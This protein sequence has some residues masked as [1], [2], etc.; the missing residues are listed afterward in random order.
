MKRLFRSFAGGEID[1]M[2]FG[3]VDLV[4]NQTGLQ[5]CKNF[6]V[7]TQGPIEN[8]PGFKFVAETKSNSTASRLIPFLFSDDQTF[9]IEVG[10]NYFR[11][12][13]SYQTL[14][15]GSPAA[16]S[17]AT[18][19]EIG[20]LVSSAGVNYYCVTPST[21]N[22]PPNATY[23]YAMPAGIYEIPHPYTEPH[24][25]ELHYVQSADVLT[26]VHPNYAPRELQRFG[27]TTWVL[28]TVSF[29]PTI[30]LPTGVSVAATVGSGSTSYAYVVTALSEED[31][32]ESY[33]SSSSSTTNDLTTAGNYNTV[34]WSAV[35]GAVRYNVYKQENG[36]FG[37][38]GQTDGTS[39]IDENV[40]PDLSQTPPIQYTPLSGAG[41]FPRAVTYFER[42]RIF[43]GTENE[44]QTSYFTKVATES[45]LSYSIPSRDDDSIKFRIASRELNVIRHMVPLRDLL[46]LSSG[47]EFR[48][49]S[50]NSD[51]ITPTT[52]S[53]RP[54]SYE[55]CNN[56]QPI[57][58]SSSVLFCQARGGRVREL[59]FDFDSAGYKANDISLLATHL[60]D[61]YTIVD[62]TFSKAPEKMAYFV[63]SDG[64][65]LVLSYVPD[66]QIIAWST[67]E[68]DGSIESVCSIPQG[69]SDIVYAVVKRVINGSTKRYIEALNARI[70]EDQEDAFFVDSGLVFDGSVQANL[71]WGSDAEAVGNTG[72]TFT[73][74]SSVFVSGDVG[75]FIYFRYKKTNGEYFTSKALI[76][77]FTSGTEVDATIR[78]EFPDV[79]SAASGAWRMTA[80]FISGLDHLEGKTVSIFGDGAVVPQ[81]VVSSG[82]ITLD[83]PVAY[84]AIGLPYFSDMQT[85]PMSIEAQSFG[86][87]SLKSVNKA[88][89]RVY[90]SGGIFAGPAFDRLQEVKQRSNEPYGTPPLLKTE[91]IPL[92]FGASWTRDGVVC[93]RQ[94]DPLPLTVL[95][96]TAELDIESMGR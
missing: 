92:A 44:P 41:N 32:E 66:Q 35:S 2:L 14:G 68:T 53:V 89:I 18:A 76:T 94:S 52:I 21:G 46:I 39:F 34:S 24:L 17:G 59:T 75:R 49:T 63:R 85:L 58:T 57:I 37:Y 47:T 74:G 15:P 62:C 20:D 48:L 27:A 28:S 33:Q 70:F 50:Q 6:N 8:R 79:G 81:K 64:V 80:T 1:P 87:G 61:Q 86:Q 10:Q 51:A 29:E 22:A 82:A 96:I 95:S 71:S 55:G 45:N 73:A 36:L 4:K 12:H 31:Q 77:G 11:F 3:R 25:F 93:L 67:L 90:R 26:I 23:W 84:A 69:Q 43:G 7:R 5:V 91:E 30:S 60:F 42:R 16:Y 54:Q 56:V 78:A 13:T 19:Y 72:V 40:G 38:I 65:C 83:Q 88:Y 9:A